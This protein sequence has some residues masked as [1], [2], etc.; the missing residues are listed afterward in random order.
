MELLRFNFARYF[1]YNSVL[2]GMDQAGLVQVMNTTGPAGA[3]YLMS[4]ISP[5]LANIEALD[6]ML[7]KLARVP[8]KLSK[9]PD[10]I[11]HIESGIPCAMF[12]IV[13]SMLSVYYGLTLS[14]RVDPPAVAILRS[15]LAAGHNTLPGK[16]WLHRLHRLLDPYKEKGAGDWENAA[17]ILQLNR[18]ADAADAAAAA[19]IYARI[20]TTMRLAELTSDSTTRT[21]TRASQRPAPAPPKQHIVD[22]SLGFTNMT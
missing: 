2:R 8:L 19:V 12:L 17:S 10:N 18:H 11:L 14:G 21:V 15:Q 20:V 16:A 6:R 1:L 5:T 22:T 3:C 7:N 13:R 9:S 4:Q